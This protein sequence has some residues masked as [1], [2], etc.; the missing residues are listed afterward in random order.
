MR[1]FILPLILLGFPTIEVLVMVLVAQKLGW[2]LLVWLII[3]FV[4]GLMLLR[5]EQF[6]LAGRLAAALVEGRDP[7]QALVASGRVMLAGFLLA[8]PGLV[9]DLLALGV[10]LWPRGKSRAPGQAREVIEGQFRRED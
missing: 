6:A 5:E 9:S 4:A 1:I 10:L 3:S 2:W 7:L 8:F